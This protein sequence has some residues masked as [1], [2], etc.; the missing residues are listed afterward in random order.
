MQKKKRKHGLGSTTT[1]W[2]LGKSQARR[3]FKATATLENVGLFSFERRIYT[4][5]NSVCLCTESVGGGRLSHNDSLSLW[6]VGDKRPALLCRTRGSGHGTRW[7]SQ[8]TWR[9]VDRTRWGVHRVEGAACPS[10][11]RSLVGRTCRTREAL[12]GFDWN[13]LAF[14]DKNT[15]FL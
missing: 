1:I 7:P 3:K 11:W 13:V 10:R 14:L 12:L 2:C 15:Y 5:Q 6:L 4:L 9:A 8:W